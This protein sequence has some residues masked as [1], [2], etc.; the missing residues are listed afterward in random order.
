MLW[1]WLKTWV[2]D[3][4]HDYGMDSIK[5]KVEKRMQQFDVSWWVKAYNHS[6]KAAVAYVDF[7]DAQAEAGSG[8]EE[9]EDEEEE[10]EEEAEE[11]EEAEDE[12]EEEG[13]A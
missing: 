10:D 2:K 8:E 5:Q 4:N 9:E 12:E 6:L 7:D 1:N 3:K 11:E 13:N